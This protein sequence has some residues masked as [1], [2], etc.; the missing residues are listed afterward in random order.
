MADLT[1]LRA[2]VA[3]D[4]T[5]TAS[6]K[7]LL[8]QLADKVDELK[9]SVEDPSA[10]EEIDAL[11]QE[12]RSNTDGLAEAAADSDDVLSDGAQT[13]PDENPTPDEPAPPVDENPLPD[14]GT[15]T[16][17][18]PDTQVPDVPPGD[19][20][21]P[22]PGEPGGPDVGVPPATEDPGPVGQPQTGEPAGDVIDGNEV[23]NPPQDGAP[24][25]DGGVA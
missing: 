25:A 1:Q 14:D 12:I 10:Q 22:A 13:P 8:S 6:V 23:T 24:E 18:N 9:D 21:N 16:P 4:S 11:V 19:V 20:E 7:T 3:A 2:A 17:G 15:G 5:V